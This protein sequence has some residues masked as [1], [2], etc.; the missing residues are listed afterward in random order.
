MD[1]CEI[2]DT[3]LFYHTKKLSEYD[4][5]VEVDVDVLG[6]IFENS[7]NEIVDIANQIEEDKT[8][9]DFSSKRKKDGVFYTPNYITKYIIQNSLGRL[10]NEKKEEIG[11]DELDYT[12]DKNIQTRTKETLLNKI[13]LYREWLLN[14]SILDPSCGSTTTRAYVC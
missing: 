2:D 11:I 10:C 9:F 14:I 6:K 8:E 4:F 13:E 5:Q 12:T 3:L 7:L 1:K